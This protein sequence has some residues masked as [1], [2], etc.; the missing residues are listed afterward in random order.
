MRVPAISIPHLRVDKDANRLPFYSAGVSGNEEQ[1][2]LPGIGE[3][4][5]TMS[6]S[7]VAMMMAGPDHRG[8][9]IWDQKEFDEQ[10]APMCDGFYVM[11]SEAGSMYVP[12]PDGWRD[13]IDRALERGVMA[14]GDT[15]E[16][17]AENAG[18]DPTAL[19]ATV[20]HWNENCAKGED[21][22]CPVPF[23]ASS[24]W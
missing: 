11:T 4:F 13:Y 1:P 16:E 14:K 8:Y 22:L 2:L 17:L 9:A 18:I 12:G 5:T 6:E 23:S 24:L 20:D 10:I 19:R 7:A 21:D 3:N 15:V